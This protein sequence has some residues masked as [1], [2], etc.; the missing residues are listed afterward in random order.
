MTEGKFIMYV[1]I[2]VALYYG[3]WALLEAWASGL[4]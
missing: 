2:A 3:A 4:L 1:L